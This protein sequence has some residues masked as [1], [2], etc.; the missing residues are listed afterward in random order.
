[1]WSI[2]TGPLRVRAVPNL[3]P[4]RLLVGQVRC[5]LVLRHNAFQV[6]LTRQPEQTFAVALNMAPS[7]QR[8]PPEDL[9]RKGPITLVAQSGTLEAKDEGLGALWPTGKQFVEPPP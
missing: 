8:L 3:P 6:V 7:C 5:L 1:V 9:A 2:Q 4:R